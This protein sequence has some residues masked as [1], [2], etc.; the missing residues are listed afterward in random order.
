MNRRTNKKQ[1]LKSVHF[2]W[3]RVNLNKFMSTSSPMFGLLLNV[4][5]VMNLFTEY[6]LRHNGNFY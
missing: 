1:L 5:S 6:K 2:R 4:E 3:P